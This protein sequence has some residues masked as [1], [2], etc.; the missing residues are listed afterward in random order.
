MKFSEY[1]NNINNEEHINEKA[2]SIDKALNDTDNVL[3]RAHVDFVTMGGDEKTAN[4]VLATK[5]HVRVHIYYNF[6]KNKVER[7]TF[8]QDML[9]AGGTWNS[10]NDLLNAFKNTSEQYVNMHNAIT[11]TVQLFKQVPY[12]DNINETL[13]KI[14]DKLY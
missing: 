13:N 2:F 4:W 7:I 3:K 14:Y 5:S 11:A 1:L 12:T 8:D 10:M 9:E 6:D